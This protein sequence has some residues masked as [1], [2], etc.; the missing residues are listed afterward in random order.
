M[1]WKA[2]EADGINLQL[3]EGSLASMEAGDFLDITDGSQ[4]GR[5]TIVE[6]IL[7]QDPAR[8]TLSPFR[9]VIP[10]IAKSPLL[11]VKYS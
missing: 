11:R 2:Q 1:I 6:I 10:D 5:Y 7:D 9:H 8:I 4:V 3:L